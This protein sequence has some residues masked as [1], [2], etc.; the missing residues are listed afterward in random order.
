MMTNNHVIV[1][2][3]NVKTVTASSLDF[4]GSKF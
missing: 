1:V 4:V 3:P 2:K